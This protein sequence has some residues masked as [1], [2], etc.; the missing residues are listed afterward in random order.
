GCAGRAGAAVAGIS[1]PPA[2]NPFTPVRSSPGS[3]G[4]SRDTGVGSRG[5][6]WADR[7]EPSRLLPCAGTT[8]DELWREV[9]IVTLEI[10]GAGGAAARAVSR[11]TIGQSG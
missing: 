5:W 2:P 9:P 8:R 7:P 6:R 3:A 11:T 10:P 1:Q 4:N